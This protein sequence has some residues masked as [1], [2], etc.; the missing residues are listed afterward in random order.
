MRTT[1]TLDPDVVR[2]LEEEMH[3]ERKSFKEVLNAAIRRGLVPG[4]A[5]PKRARYRVEAH[6]TRLLPGY[7]PRGF[8]RLADELEDTAVVRKAIPKRR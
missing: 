8:N 3:R 1:V 5:A 7:D 6:E 2:L 4:R